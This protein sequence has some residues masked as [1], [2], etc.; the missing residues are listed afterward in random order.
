MAR[1]DID[2][3]G[4]QRSCCGLAGNFGFE[5][6]HY[7]VSRAS[8][9][10]LLLPAVEGAADDAVLMADGYSCRTQVAQLAGRRAA[11]LAEV[12]AAGLEDTD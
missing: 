9:E 12:L 3:R 8:A 7:D 5:N 1:A 2:T 11:H 10:R 4:M 6:G